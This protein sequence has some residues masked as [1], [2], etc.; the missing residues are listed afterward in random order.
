MSAP[1]AKP[2]HPVR[3]VRTLSPLAETLAARWK[4]RMDLAAAAFNA[5][6]HEAGCAHVAVASHV[7]CHLEV[8]SKRL[9][10]ESSHA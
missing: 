3:Y 9:T 8:T 2:V 10:P 7:G 4:A 6:D 1:D 5:G